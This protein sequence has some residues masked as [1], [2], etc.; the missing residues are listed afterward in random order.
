MGYGTAQQMAKLE[1]T[2]R[3]EE[4]REDALK[5]VARERMDLANMASEERVENRRMLRLM[6][7]EQKERE[8]EEAIM[9]V[10]TFFF[11]YSLFFYK[12]KAQ[13]F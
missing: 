7:L 9:R 3:K 11:A 10:Y 4:N 6:Q 12:E 8:M 5:S 1:S 2:R 13:Y